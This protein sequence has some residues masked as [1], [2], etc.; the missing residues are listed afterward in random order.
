MKKKIAIL[1]ST[2]SIGSTLLSLIDKKNYE[3]ALLVA[4]KKYKKVLSKLKTNNFL[5]DHPTVSQFHTKSYV[6]HLYVGFPFYLPEQPTVRKN[7][8]PL[9]IHAPSKPKFKGTDII[10]EAIQEVKDEGYD[11]DYEELIE[12]PNTHVLEK[13]QQCHF[14]INQLYSDTPMSG[15]DTEAAWFGKASIIGGYNL[16]MVEK[17]I[18]GYDVP[19]TYRIYPTKENLKKAIIHLLTD[20]NYCENLGLKA[21]E[22][23]KKNWDAKIV[24]QKYLDIINGDIPD[25]IMRSPLDDLDIYGF[26]IN[27]DVRKN[28]IK[29][30]IKN[31]GTESLCLSQHPRLEDTIIKDCEINY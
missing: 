16:D 4:N 15:L 8:R 20:G 19:P 24:A 6:P 9:I 27:D 17:S 7:I 29:N 31:Y 26:G 18:N 2:G 28:I 22:F 5:I 13:I 21:Q 14:V 3:I 11:F 25:Y 10:R 23:V 30:M 12:V 1:G